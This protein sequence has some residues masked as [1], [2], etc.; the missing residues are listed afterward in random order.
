VERNLERI[1][2]ASRHIPD[3]VKATTPHIPWRDIAG[4]GNILRHDDPRVDP[5][6]IWR[7][8]DRDLKPLRET[9]E[10]MLREIPDD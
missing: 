9:V 8:V 6:E 10:A 2:E 5:R 4:V 1:S 3:T 7:T